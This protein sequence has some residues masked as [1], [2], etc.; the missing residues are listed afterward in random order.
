MQANRALNK[1]VKTLGGFPAY[2]DE[3]DEEKVDDL[4]EL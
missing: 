2:R 1:M 4:Q 3:D